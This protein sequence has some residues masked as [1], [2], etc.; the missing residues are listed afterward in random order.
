MFGLMMLL[1]SISQLKSSGT[2]LAECESECLHNSF[3]A[4]RAISVELSCLLFPLNLCIYYFVTE[5]SNKRFAK[6]NYC[7]DMM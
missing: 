4:F 3:V 7:D 1:Q 2:I 5:M 6:L